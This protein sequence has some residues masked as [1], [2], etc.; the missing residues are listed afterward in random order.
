M[1]D[2]RAELL[3]QG[4]NKLLRPAY[5][6]LMSLLAKAEAKAAGYSWATEVH[7]FPD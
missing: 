4:M 6:A 7:N 5:E 3:C 1:D 2:H